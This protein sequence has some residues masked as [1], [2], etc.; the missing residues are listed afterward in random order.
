MTVLNELDSA[1]FSTGQVAPAAFASLQ[2]RGFACVV[3][4][5][6]DGEEPGQPTA[7]SLRLAAESAGL[8]FIHLPVSG[9][10]NPAA[11]EGTREALEGLQPGE[12]ILMF[13]RSG[14]RSTAAWAM[15]RAAMGDDPRDLRDAAASAGYD[16]SRLPL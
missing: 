4:H 15:A 12:K 3:C 5:R 7:E 11:V 9:L 16:L 8:R 6:P 13:C 14:M 10:P 1:T 2:Q